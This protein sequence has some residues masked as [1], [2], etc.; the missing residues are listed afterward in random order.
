[1]VKLS[2]AELMAYIDGA[3]STETASRIEASPEYIARVQELKHLQAGIRASVHR[4]ECPDPLSLGEYQQGLIQGEKALLIHA[5]LAK[6]PHCQKEM[7]QLKEFLT[8]RPGLFER[9][10]VGIASLISGGQPGIPAPAA[11]LRGRGEAPRI[12]AAEEVQIVLNVQ[13]DVRR[14]E[15]KVL[16]GLVMG[17]PP[18]GGEV[19]LL[20]GGD[21]IAYKV[22]DDLGHFSFPDLASGEYELSLYLPEEEIQVPPFRLE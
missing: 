18:T 15:R 20:Q 8:P 7:A 3:V 5:H 21:M 9:A 13:V 4:A 11:G 1:M 19:H 17:L 22:V 12:Y 2:D 14:P 6:C 10:R 16:A